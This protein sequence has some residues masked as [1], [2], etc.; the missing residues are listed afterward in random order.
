MKLFKVTNKSDYFRASSEGVN[1]HLASLEKLTPRTSQGS[2]LTGYSLAAEAVVDF[3]LD[4][5]EGLYPTF[6]WRET[7][8]CPI[9]HL[10][11]R[12]RFSLMVIDFLGNIGCDDDVYAME[13]RTYFYKILK[14][15]FPKLIGSE[16]FGPNVAGGEIFPDGTMHQDATSFSFNDN[17]FQAVLAFDVFEHIPDYLTA[18]TECW[19]I[20]KPNG[21]LIFT[22]PFLPESEETSI[23]ATL[24]QNGDIRHI[25]EPEYHGDPMSADGVLCFQH[26]GWD[27]ID[28]C[29]SAGFSEAYGIAGWS[30]GLGF[31]E[32]QIVFIAEK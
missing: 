11:N 4:Y 26:F 2:K 31:M 8:T 16:Y 23:R 6:L 14:E 22:A 28:A 9:T 15:R 5:I 19:R 18:L 30:I 32:P 29:E 13:Q 12:M 20:L 7:V 24:L 1:R 21:K 10:N 25:L 17:Q 3:R 27:I